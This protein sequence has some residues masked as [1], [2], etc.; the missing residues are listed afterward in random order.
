MCLPHLIE[1]FIGRIINFNR[2]LPRI[3]TLF[4]F[5]FIINSQQTLYLVGFRQGVKARVGA[6]VLL[7]GFC[8]VV[9]QQNQSVTNLIVQFRRVVVDSRQLDKRCAVE[10]LACLVQR[11]Q[12]PGIRFI[13]PERQRKVAQLVNECQRHHRVNGRHDQADAQSKR[14]VHGLEVFQPVILPLGLQ[15]FA[16]HDVRHDADDGENQHEGNETGHDRRGAVPKRIRIDRPPLVAHPLECH[17]TEPTG[18]VHR[19]DHA[20]QSDQC[21]D[22]AL[23]I[24]LKREDQK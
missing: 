23:E 21:V 6:H 4:I 17:R 18:K 8:A 12:Q 3:I 24:T 19:Q 15:P 9:Q 11:L 2:I 13:V 10:L 20:K 5:I 7:D 22:S 14:A 1:G 16:H